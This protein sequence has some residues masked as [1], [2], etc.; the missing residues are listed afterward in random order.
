MIRLNKTG[1]K[2]QKADNT[3]QPFCVYIL[4]AFVR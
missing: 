3:Y 4:I 1:N 2:T